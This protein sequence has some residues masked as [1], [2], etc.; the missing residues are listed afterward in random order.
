MSTTTIDSP[1]QR[2][3]DRLVTWRKVGDNQY[4]ARCPAHNDREPSLSISAG[5]DGRAILHC[6]AGCTF[7]AIVSAL[8]LQT[9]DLFP[10]NGRAQSTSEKRIVATYDYDD[11]QGEL[12][13]QCVRYHPRTFKQR[14]PDGNGDWI[15]NL[16]GTPKVLYRLRDLIDADLDEWV[17]VPEGEKD[18]EAV[19][20]LGF[21]ATCNPMGAGKWRLV[22]DV[23]LERRRVAIIPDRDDAGRK[24]A[25]DV[26]QRLHG[27][28]AE[29]RIVELPGGGKDASDWIEAGG[30]AAD[31]HQLIDASPV[32]SPKAEETPDDADS[33]RLVLDPNDPLPSAREFIR[34]R[35]LHDEGRRLQHYAGDFYTWNGAAYQRA[36]DVHIRG[37]L[38]DFLEQAQRWEIKGDNERLVPFKPSKS[39]VDNVV[40]ALRT[41]VH[42]TNEV[43]M[44][45]WLGIGLGEDAGDFVP[46]RNG[47]LHTPTLRL[48]KP[49]PAMF[50]SYAL[51][52]DYDDDAEQPP[53]AWLTFLHDLWPDDEESIT[54]LQEWFAY[55][56]SGATQLHKI[57]LLVGPKRS[58]K[59]TTGRL[60]RA[61]VG[62]EN[63]AGPTLASLQTNFGLWALLGKPLAIIGDARLS[64]RA[65]QQAVVERLLSISGEDALTIDRKNLEPVTLQ[66][67]TRFMMLSNELP[68]LA[69][70]SGALASRFL[71]LTLSNSW[72]GREDVHLFDR[73]RRELPRILHWSLAGRQ[74][75]HDRGR[76]IQPESAAD[77]IRDLED[78]ASPINAFIADQCELGDEHE[79]T[80]GDLFDRWR[81]WCQEQGRTHPGTKQ[82]FGRDLRS[83]MPRL[84]TRRPRAGGNRERLYVGIRLK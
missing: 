20:A 81:L 67:P 71:V 83:A 73:L 28:A 75:L 38:Y 50:N 41:V 68:R 72:L 43:R 78:L 76:F 49:T 35:W 31:L 17:I 57:L 69:D 77:A 59:T 13:F 46:C 58:G 64:G 48:Y 32:F 47:L 52:I 24:H 8:G 66:L 84:R 23:I 61:L 53:T 18:V 56:I 60:L 42:V 54:A 62:E 74:R 21:V 10:S 22:D 51:P 45:S 25:A 7:D 14:R 29:V 40:D 34:R 65:D 55:I 26:A 27:R 79:V 37:H 12:L 2:V 63:V 9:R 30:T 1:V 15:W 3:L 44:P 70:A 19:H 33:G 82:A 16:N 80:A 5:R 36:E 4:Q 6:H 39:K 11:A